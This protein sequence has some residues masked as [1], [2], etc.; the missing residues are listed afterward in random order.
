MQGRRH[1]Q[2]VGFVGACTW[3]VLWYLCLGFTRCTVAVG[4]LELDQEVVAIVQNCPHSSV[5]GFEGACTCEV[6][7][8]V[9]IASHAP[10][11]ILM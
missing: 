1:D 5:F 11:Y 8:P 6:V 9:I 4:E 7:T 2:I 10:S 3:K